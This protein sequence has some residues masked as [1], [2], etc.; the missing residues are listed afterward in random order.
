MPF[1]AT[2]CHHYANPLFDA[3]CPFALFPK[4]G[5]NV[6][7]NVPSMEVLFFRKEI[8]EEMGVKFG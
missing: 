8:F 6:K 7:K 4:Q 3:Q 5:I 2:S 1:P